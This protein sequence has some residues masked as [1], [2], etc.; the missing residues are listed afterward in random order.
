MLHETVR[1]YVLAISHVPEPVP[2]STARFGSSIGAKYRLP[3][4]H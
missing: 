4:A 3:D 1:I 2:I